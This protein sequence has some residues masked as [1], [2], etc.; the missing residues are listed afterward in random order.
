MMLYK[1][2]KESGEVG[3][4]DLDAVIDV[5]RGPSGSKPLWSA[6]VLYDPEAEIFIET[7]D[8]PTENAHGTPSET[9]EVNEGYLQTYFSLTSKDLIRIRR[10]PKKWRFRSA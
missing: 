9:V 8:N 5:I 4:F 2:T 6:L 7:R 3:Q 1:Y 10:S